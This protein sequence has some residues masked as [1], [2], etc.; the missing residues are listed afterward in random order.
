MRW[1][2]KSALQNAISVLPG[3]VAVNGLLQRYGTGSVVMTPERVVARLVRVGGR[4]V[5]H[6]R[7]FGE[8]PLEE[9]TVVEVGT[10]FVP[11]LPVG[12]YLAGAAAVHTYDIARLAN[13]ARTADL[14]RQIVA[15]ADSGALERECPWTLPD[16]LER[17][18]ARS[19]PH[20]PA[21]LIRCSR[22]W[23]SPTTSAT[24]PG[25]ASPPD[26]PSS[27]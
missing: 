2:A 27:S 5:E 25:R 23:A 8:Q 18:R 22:P 10:G 14:L 17:L 7:R 6:Q 11:L 12:L 1:L 9:T 16:R 4:H 24:R 13:T 15:A 19:R 26:R 21:G 3:S 20:P